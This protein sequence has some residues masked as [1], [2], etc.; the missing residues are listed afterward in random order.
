MSTLTSLPGLV[1]AICNFHVTIREKI[2]LHIF[3]L[4]QD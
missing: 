2:E 1:V 4:K 3:E